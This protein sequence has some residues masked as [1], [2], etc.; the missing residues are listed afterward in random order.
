MRAVLPFVLVVAL[1]VPIAVAQFGGMGGPKQPT[2]KPVKSDIPFIK[3]QVCEQL[4]KAAF[5]QVKAARDKVKPGHKVSRLVCH[6]PAVCSKGLTHCKL[7]H[8]H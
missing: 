3:C 2:F 1:V 5:R 7:C 8:T 6:K 4:A